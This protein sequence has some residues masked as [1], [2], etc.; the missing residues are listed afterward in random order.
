MHQYGTST[1]DD[2]SITFYQATAK[3]SVHRF[4]TKKEYIMKK[5]SRT[6]SVQTEANVDIPTPSSPST[7]QL[8]VSLSTQDSTPCTSTPSKRAKRNLRQND[9][10]KCAKCSIKY[11]TKM[12]ETYDS[13][14]VNCESKN[15]QFWCHMKC[16]GMHCSNEAMFSESVKFFCKTHNPASSGH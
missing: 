1:G 15:C 3:K 11:G 2:V 4:S 13:V 14:W 9:P 7:P 10:N 6:V 16:L 5:E 8:S 12:D